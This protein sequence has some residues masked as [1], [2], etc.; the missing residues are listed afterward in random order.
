MHD[1]SA[2][3]LILRSTSGQGSRWIVCQASNF[4][5]IP[6]RSFLYQAFLSTIDSIDRAPSMGAMIHSCAVVPRAAWSKRTA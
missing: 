2:M 5:D 1:A 6:K 3:E 4:A